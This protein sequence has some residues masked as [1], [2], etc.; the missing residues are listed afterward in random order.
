MAR[1]L[2][3]RPG[4]SVDIS[5][6]LVRSGACPT[7][8]AKL[9]L[10]S[11]AI[12]NGDSHRPDPAHTVLQHVVAN[13][14]LAPLVSDEGEHVLEAPLDCG[15]MAFLEDLSARKYAIVAATVKITTSPNPTYCH[16]ADGTDI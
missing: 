15:V 9:L 12:L 7:A 3:A 13:H 1:L 8:L 14:L 10:I 2:R 16:S 11:V 5:A 4:E 6:P